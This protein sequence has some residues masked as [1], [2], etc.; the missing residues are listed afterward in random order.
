VTYTGAWIHGTDPRASGGT[1]A[2]AETAGALATLSFTGTQVRLLGARNSNNGQ[3]R[4]SID[5]VF[6][7][8][9]DTYGPSL[10][11]AVLFTATGLHNGGHSMTVEVTGTRN[12]ASSGN[13]VIIDA[14]DVTP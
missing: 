3:A 13:W 14:F 2:E 10:E 8:E 11:M 5:G 4:V 9:V 7:G 12:S 6:M 1:F